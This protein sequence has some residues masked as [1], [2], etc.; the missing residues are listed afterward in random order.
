MDYSLRRMTRNSPGFRA[1]WGE[2]A[3]LQTWAGPSAEWPGTA[4]GFS[5]T[6]SA[7]T[8]RTAS[9]P[10]YLLAP[11]RHFGSLRGRRR[12]RSGGM[13]RVVAA[14]SGRRGMLC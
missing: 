6:C 13:T 3:G 5:P 7:G 14:P 1:I 4:R 11:R 10:R 12:G 9:T 2:G 8:S